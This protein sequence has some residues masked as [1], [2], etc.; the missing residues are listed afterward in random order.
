MASEHFFCIKPRS[1]GEKKTVLL[2]GGRDADT[3][4]GCPEI[5]I[6]KT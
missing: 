4:Y 2:P 3:G 1:I 5:I 6:G